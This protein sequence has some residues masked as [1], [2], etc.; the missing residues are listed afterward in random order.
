VSS[1]PTRCATPAGQASNGWRVE[2]NAEKDEEIVAGK[3]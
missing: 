2:E 3:G 1:P